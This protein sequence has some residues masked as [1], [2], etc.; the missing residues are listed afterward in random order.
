MVKSYS[1][2]NAARYNRRWRTFTQKTL[3]E[4]IHQIDRATLQDRKHRLGR[5]PRLLDIACGTGVLLL[6]LIKNIPD[7]EV[8]G[9]DA[10]SDMLAQARAAL[11]AYPTVQLAQVTLGKDK[12]AHSVSH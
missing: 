5:V 9:I 7:A 1:G 6:W 11:H 8:Y 3:T 10:S 4:T 2:W 12:S